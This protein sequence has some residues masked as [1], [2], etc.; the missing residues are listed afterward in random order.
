MLIKVAMN[1]RGK[2]FILKA[3]ADVQ[4]FHSTGGTVF[5]KEGEP[6]R[7]EGVVLKEEYSDSTGKFPSQWLVDAC[8]VVPMS[9]AEVHV[10]VSGIKKH[11]D[12]GV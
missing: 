6:W 2:L 7:S 12:S 4:P 1:G 5:S 11:D 10:D 3:S 9:C 8:G